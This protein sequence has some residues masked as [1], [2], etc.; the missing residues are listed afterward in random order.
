M[1]AIL[2]FGPDSYICNLIFLFSSYP[3]KVKSIAISRWAFDS[4]A[5]VKCIHGGLHEL[6]ETRLFSNVYHIRRSPETRGTEHYK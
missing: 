1:A 5:T 3:N 2:D 4:Y 6:V